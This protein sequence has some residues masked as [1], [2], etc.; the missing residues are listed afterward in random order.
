[1]MTFYE[2]QTLVSERVLTET[3][4]ELIIDAS[5]LDGRLIEGTNS[6]NIV[7]Y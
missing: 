1:M 7:N 3:T 6:V 2:V 4:T 5:L